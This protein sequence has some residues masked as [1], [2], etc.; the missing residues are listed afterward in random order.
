MSDPWQDEA[1]AEDDWEGESTGP[2]G[3]SPLDPEELEE[4][5]DDSELWDDEPD[6]DA[7]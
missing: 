3:G 2:A 7:A 1:D 5:E 4:D 6:D